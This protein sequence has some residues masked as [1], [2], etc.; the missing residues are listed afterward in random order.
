MTF[1]TELLSLLEQPKNQWPKF[2]FRRI[3][4][5]FLIL[6]VICLVISSLYIG[7]AGYL[8]YILHFQDLLVFLTLAIARIIH[9]S[10]ATESR[11]F[12]AYSYVLSGPLLVLLTAVLAMPYTL[13]N[14]AITGQNAWEVMQYPVAIKSTLQMGVMYGSIGMHIID[15]IISF[16]F[17]ISKNEKGVKTIS[18]SMQVVSILFVAYFMQ[19]IISIG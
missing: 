9:R 19:A 17:Y 4:L 10:L 15:S 12:T 2:T 11:Q 1:F 18:I 8:I 5:I 3:C 14:S 6:V 16:F 13:D 7:L